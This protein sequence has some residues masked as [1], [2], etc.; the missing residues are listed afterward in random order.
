MDARGRGD[1]QLCTHAVCTGDEHRL[2]PALDIQG[3]EP[4]EGAD[5]AHHAAREGTRGHAADTFL[6]L[7]GARDIHAGF[8]IAHVFRTWFLPPQDTQNRHVSGTPV[9]GTADDE[10]ATGAKA[11][12]HYPTYPMS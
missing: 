3:K 6:G 1:F 4:A 2:T 12:Q 7:F 8:G 11:A 10:I 9:P 5:A